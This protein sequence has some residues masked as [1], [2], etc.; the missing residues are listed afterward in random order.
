MHRYSST[1][2]GF[3]FSGHQ[4]LD[5]ADTYEG[6]AEELGPNRISLQIDN[7]GCRVRS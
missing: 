2:H 7:G 6:L 5:Q 4:L 1:I 3:A